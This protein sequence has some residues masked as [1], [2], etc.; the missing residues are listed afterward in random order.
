[1]ATRTPRTSAREIAARERVR[2]RRASVWEREAKLEDL[3]TSFLL[4]EEGIAD[5]DKKAEGKIARY[6][7]R[8]RA[9]A[10]KDKQPLLDRQTSSA[11]EMLGMEGIRVVADML[12]VPADVMREFKQSQEDRGKAVS[13]A[14]SGAGSSSIEAVAVEV[15]AEGHRSR[16]E[17]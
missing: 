16:Q 12:Q 2:E 5:I 11:R 10:E 7:E 6:A 3:A 14:E 13:I 17:I 15:A 1:M 4:A 9:E 8:I